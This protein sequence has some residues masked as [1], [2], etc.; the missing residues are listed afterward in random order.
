VQ[1]N[2]ETTH[3]LSS[4]TWVQRLQSVDLILEMEHLLLLLDQT[5]DQAV[6][7]LQA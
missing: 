3:R 2:T 5:L 1:N 7:V 4:I 6:K